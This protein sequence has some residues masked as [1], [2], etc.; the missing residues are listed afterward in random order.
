VTTNH[1]DGPPDELSDSEL[2]AV[3]FAA[4]DEL[5]EYI[6]ATSH[7]DAALLAIM[8]AGDT[9]PAEP[10]HPSDGDQGGGG[11]RSLGRS[12][13]RPALALAAACVVVLAGG[14][15]ARNTLSGSKS[16][17]GV[18]TAVLALPGCTT[19]VA[20]GLP[21][22]QVRS[23]R[24]STGRG[25]P[26]DVVISHGFAFVSDV[27]RGVAVLSITKH[28]PA[29]LWTAHVRGARGEALTRDHLLV[30][31]GSGITVFSVGA[32]EHGPAKPIGK[33]SSPGEKHAV[34]V[35]VTPDGQF[36]FVTFQGSADVGV[37]NLHQA[38]ASNFTSGLVGMIPVGH[39]PTGIAISPDGRY[40]YVTSGMAS[41]AAPGTGVLNVIDA[42]KAEEHPSAF[43]VVKSVPAGC[44]PSRVVTSGQEVWVTA[45]GSNA[46]LAF[47]APRLL[48]D[49]GH[50]LVA[51]VGVGANPIG[52]ALIRGGAEIVVADS[53]LNNLAD[54]L[55]NL[56]IVSTSNALA[57]RPALLG[58]VRSGLVPLELALKPDGKTL[59]VTNSA[60]HQLQAVDVADLP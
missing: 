28:V 49:P 8:A 51:R 57:G 16:V 25:Q 10:E 39:G 11:S 52:L 43:A 31:A 30:A 33:L 41:P 5:L 38:L 9:A 17:G 23:Q 53:N 34:G 50:A 14:Y 48:N 19:R 26:F 12:W 32:L 2:D 21:L 20:S 24:V 27:S 60:S 42:H 13:L 36:A 15:L 29:L 18:Q 56:A 40:A 44:Q 22:P 55:P 58:L 47:S 54:E 6:R 7:P 1:G 4:D 45:A 59:L 46:L 3:L 37:F 35:A